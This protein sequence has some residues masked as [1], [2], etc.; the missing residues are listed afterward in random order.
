MTSQSQKYPIFYK[1]WLNRHIKKPVDGVI[2]L[3]ILQEINSIVPV[4]PSIFHPLQVK[5]LFLRSIPSTL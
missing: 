5:N 2:K 4:L 3:K 1:I